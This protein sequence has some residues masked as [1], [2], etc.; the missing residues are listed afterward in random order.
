MKKLVG[1]ILSGV[2]VGAYFLFFILFFSQ[3]LMEESGAPVYGFIFLI[4]FLFVPL[5]SIIYV[6]YERVREIQ[7]GEEEEAKK[8]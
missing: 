6:V 7:N 8:Y 2:L 3:I 1:P 4:C 5:F